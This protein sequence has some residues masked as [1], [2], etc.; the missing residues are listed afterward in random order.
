M[1]SAQINHHNDLTMLVPSSIALSKQV[2]DVID[3]LVLKNDAHLVSY[4]LYPT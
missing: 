3:V 1:L 4:E 2:I